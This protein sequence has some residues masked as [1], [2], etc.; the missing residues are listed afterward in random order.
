ML[1]VVVIS[2]DFSHFE[3]YSI[4]SFSLV[5]ASLHSYN[6]FSIGAE[7]ILEI[8]FLGSTLSLSSCAAL[9]QLS[10]VGFSLSDPFLCSREH[11]FL[12][13]FYARSFVCLVTPNVFSLLS[14]P[15]EYAASSAR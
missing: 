2:Y 10:N 3:G 11:F 9:V 6:E 4:S 14:L 7:C 13:F 1:F 8:C 12:H 5:S 15:C